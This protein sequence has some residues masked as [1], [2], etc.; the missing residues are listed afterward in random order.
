M[1]PY[2]VLGVSP[3]ATD[4][5]IKKAYRVLSRKYH[6]DANVGNPN[7]KEY[8]ERFKE[9][10]QA[11]NTIMDQRSGKDQYNYGYSQGGFYGGSQGEQSQT[12]Q[13]MQAAAN[14]I[15]NGMYD[16][17]LNVLNNIADRNAA[18]YAMSAKANS[19]KGNNV[20][21]LE[22]AKKAS[23]MEPGN[24]EYQKLVQQLESG[25]S[26]YN[27]QS[28]QYGG[29]TFGTRGCYSICLPMLCCSM[30]GGRFCCFPFQKFYDRYADDELKQD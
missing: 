11:Y 30:C 3:N 18:W 29:T 2:E 25:G 8:E 21:A 1:N 19:G 28:Q 5:E 13:Y 16:E 20:L 15:R 9:V 22:H 12:N 10:Q 6:P 24:F 17:A 23:S 27:E 7:Q 26:W 4:D 14:Y